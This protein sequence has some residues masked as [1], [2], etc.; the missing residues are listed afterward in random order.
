VL[1]S[2]DEVESNIKERGLLPDTPSASEIQSRGL[3]LGASQGLL[4]RKVE[5][6]TLYILELKRND[7][8]LRTENEQL[9]S[10]LQELRTQL[11]Q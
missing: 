2:L 7:E 11:A 3:S 9:K 1:P 8:A 10:Q 5:K 6:L 4:M